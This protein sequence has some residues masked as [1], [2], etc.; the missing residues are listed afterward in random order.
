[1]LDVARRYN[2]MPEEIYSEQGKKADDG[3]LSKVL[4]YE[5]FHQSRCPAALT[6]IDAA[7]CYDSIAHTIA[8][9][10]FQAFGVS[11]NAVE[12]MLTAI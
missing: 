11:G 12:A 5:I 8:S 1:M 6:S 9:L 7:N 3:L 4:L 10:F 2:F